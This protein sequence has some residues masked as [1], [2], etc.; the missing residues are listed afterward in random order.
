[1]FSYTSFIH[2][3]VIHF[4]YFHWI[5]IFLIIFRKFVT[6]FTAIVS[7][8]MFQSCFVH[9]KL[10]LFIQFQK[11]QCSYLVSLMFLLCFIHSQLLLLLQFHNTCFYHFW[12]I[13]STFS[14]MF[15][16]LCLIKTCVLF[17]GYVCSHHFASLVRILAYE[18]RINDVTKSRNF[19]QCPWMFESKIK[20]TFKHYV[21]KPQG[22]G[23]STTIALQVIFWQ[24]Y[25][26]K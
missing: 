24:K 15:W 21:G 23:R 8:D 6:F 5:S 10:L 3:I 12:V 1:M 4:N 25:I 22:Y 20:E 2:K 26:M 14:T 9:S 19:T 13:F 18:N 11:T 16:S 7:K 17:Q